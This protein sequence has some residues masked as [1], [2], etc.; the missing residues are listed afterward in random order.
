[1]EVLE[2]TI[3]KYNDSEY[4]SSII[5]YTGK[6]STDEYNK[7]SETDNSYT[8]NDVVGKLGIE[9]YMDSDLKGEKGHEKLYVDYLGKAVEVIEHEEPQAGN[10]VYLSIDRDLQIAVYNLLEQDIA[11]IVSSNIGNP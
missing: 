5:G 3:R 11:G 7:L 6:I 10:D 4:F 9:Q 2:D 8:L 1:M